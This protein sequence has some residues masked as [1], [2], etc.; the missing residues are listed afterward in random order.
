MWKEMIIIIQDEF[1]EALFVIFT[2]DYL[3]L[4]TM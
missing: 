4:E 2:K 3:L 1:P